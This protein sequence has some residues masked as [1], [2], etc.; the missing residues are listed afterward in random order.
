MS[1]R[2]ELRLDWC[3]YEAA[4][5]AVENW[6]Y[7]QTMPIGKL[8]KIG[9][10]EGDEFVGCVVFGRGASPQI[11]TPYKLRQTEICELVRVAIKSHSWPVSRILSIA[12]KMLLRS[13]PG[14]RMVVSFADPQH[15]HHGGVYQANGWVYAG[16]STPKPLLVLS[17]GDTRH[18][19]LYMGKNKQPIPRGA[20]WSQ[21]TAKHRYLMPLD[22]EIRK[23][24]EPLRKPYPKRVRSEDSGTPGYQPG[25]GGA[26][27]T[28]TLDK[29]SL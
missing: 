1:S 18:N 9:V 5:Y 6:H 20:K 15:G 7:S 22:D 25:G 29:I 24:I 17:N 27:P 23:R 10:W 4:K 19:R 16:A 14:I 3:T 8:V 2:P 28:R 26:I 13:M 12:L 21:S 11:G